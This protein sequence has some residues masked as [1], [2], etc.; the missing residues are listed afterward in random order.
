MFISCDKDLYPNEQ[1]NLNAIKR[2]AGKLRMG[3]DLSRVSSPMLVCMVIT[4]SRVWINRVR[5]SILLV[6]G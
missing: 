1:R 5:L 4:Y 6:V 2:L 3:L